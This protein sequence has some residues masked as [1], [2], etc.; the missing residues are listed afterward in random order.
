MRQIPSLRVAA[1]FHPI[2]YTAIDMF[3]PLRNNFNRKTL[4]EAQVVIFACMTTRA[5]SAPFSAKVK[6]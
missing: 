2:S 3:G 5:V 4:K 6:L 1:G